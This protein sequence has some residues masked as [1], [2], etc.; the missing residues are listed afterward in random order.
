EEHRILFNEINQ[1]AEKVGSVVSE[2]FEPNIQNL[3]SLRYISENPQY[4]SLIEWEKEQSDSKIVYLHL[5]K[6][7]ELLKKAFLRILKK[8]QRDFLFA[9]PYHRDDNYYNIQT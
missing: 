3:V 1:N 7:I 8:E 9:E 4:K 2:R 5:V 6:C